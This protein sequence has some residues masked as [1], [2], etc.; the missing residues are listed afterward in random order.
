M[1][2]E[3]RD[4][5]GR[6]PEASES[7]APGAVPLPA[8]SVRRSSW[9]FE[10]LELPSHRREEKKDLSLAFFSAP[11]FFPSPTRPHPNNLALSPR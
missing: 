6:V 3:V 5:R 10:P 1:G 8:R 2:S 11:T 9:Y 7:H 4:G